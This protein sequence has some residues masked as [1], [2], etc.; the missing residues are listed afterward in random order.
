VTGTVAVAHRAA[1]RLD[2]LLL[3][4]LSVRV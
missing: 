3:Y 2:S 1:G 4:G